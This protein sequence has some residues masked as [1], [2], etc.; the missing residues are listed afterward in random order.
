[1]LNYCKNYGN[2]F[3][4]KSFQSIFA[5]NFDKMKDKILEKASKMFMSLG[6]KNV[7]MDD[8]A[9][10][11]GISKKTIYQHFSNKTELVKETASYLFD[12]ITKGIDEIYRGNKNPIEELFNVKNYISDYFKAGNQSTIYQFQKYYPKIHDTLKKKH[13]EKLETCINKNINRGIK[14]GLFR[15]DIDI[16]IIS[17]IYFYGSSN[18][19][20]NDYFPIEKFNPEKVQLE[21]LEYHIRGIGTSKGI[22]KLEQLLKNQL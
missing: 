7:T 9:N 20:D 11:M 17:R 4:F 19:K 16:S 5:R 2:F 13:L 12:E 15:N 18:L 8:I 22:I 10:E 14:D 6:F 1:M 21:F 3:C